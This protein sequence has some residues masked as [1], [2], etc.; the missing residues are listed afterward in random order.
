MAE[1][2]GS[3]LSVPDWHQR[4]VCSA[5]GSRRVDY[6]AIDGMSKIHPKFPS[7][8]GAVKLIQAPRRVLGRLVTAGILAA[9]LPAMAPLGATNRDGRWLRQLC[10]STE[11]ADVSV[12]DA[13]ILGIFDSNP[14]RPKLQRI[15]SQHASTRLWRSAVSGTDGSNPPLQGGSL[16]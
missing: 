9:L 3:E 1:R 11:P 5:C 13:Y 14:N 2:Y 10:T 4:L 8:L 12:C 15:G 7:N 6:V 16:H